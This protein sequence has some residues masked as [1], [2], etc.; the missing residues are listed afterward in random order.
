LQRKEFVRAYHPRQVAGRMESAIAWTTAASAVAVIQ[1]VRD[2][3]L[4]QRG[5]LKQEEVPLA[6]FLASRTG[7]MFSDRPTTGD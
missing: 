2:G 6:A 4:P 7:S 1:L 5:F 3:V